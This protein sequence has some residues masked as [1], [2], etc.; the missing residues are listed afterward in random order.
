MTAVDEARAS[1]ATCVPQSS[2]PHRLRPH[3]LVAVAAAVDGLQIH[4]RGT[5]V[6]AC[7]TGKTLVG[8]RVAEQLLADRT[9]PRVLVL[10]PSIA[11][12]DQSFREWRQN[13]TVPFT[14]LAICSDV[15]V[16]DDEDRDERVDELPLTVTTDVEKVDRWLA[17]DGPGMQVVFC[18]YHSSPLLITQDEEREP[19]DL[20]IADEAHRCAGKTDGDFK[21]I[22]ADD[23]IPADKRLFLTAT[24]RITGTQSNTDDV[25]VATMDNEKYFGPRLH[26]LTFREAIDLGLLSDY[27][28]AIITVTDQD[29]HRLVLNHTQLRLTDDPIDEDQLDAATLAAQLA[30]INAAKEHALHRVLVFH[31]RL[32]R[33]RRF[34]K[35]LAMTINS[36]AVEDRPAARL[37]A[38]HIEGA[39]DSE[40]KSFILNHLREVGQAGNTEWMVLSNVKCLSEGID[41]PTLDGIMF[42]EPRTSQIDVAQAVGR[43]IRL[44]PLRQGQPAL[45]ILPVYLNEAESPE[46][47]IAESEFRHIYQTI[48]AL[49]DHDEDFAAKLQVAR[50]RMGQGLPPQIPDNITAINASRGLD[51]QFIDAFSIRLIERTTVSWEAYFGA[52]QQHIQRHD[53][54]PLKS[55]VTDDGLR[56]GQWALNQRVL[57][58]AGQLNPERLRR[59]EAFEC[60]TW[61]PRNATWEANFAALQRY[62]GEHGS[63]PTGSYVTDDGLRIG[64]WVSNLRGLYHQGSLTPDRISRL[65]QL[66]GWTWS[67]GGGG[68]RDLPSWESRFAALE[69]YV[70]QH[71]SLPGYTYVCDDGFG[72]GK[73]IYHQRARYARG[74]L[75]DD[76]A[77][78]LEVLPGWTWNRRSITRVAG[79]D[80]SVRFAALQAYV[81]EHASIPV[82]TCVT[83]DGFK[84]GKWVSSQRVSYAKGRLP[85]DRIEQLEQIPGWLWNAARSDSTDEAWAAK[86][87]VLSQYVAENDA[88]PTYEHVADDGVRLGR[89]I[90]HQRDAHTRGRLSADRVRLL[91]GLPH[92]TWRRRQRD[93]LTSTRWET[94]FEAL[95]R[96]LAHNNDIIPDKTVVDQDGLPVGSWVARMRQRYKSG[97]L[98]ADYIRRLEE[99]DGWDWSPRRA[100]WDAHYQG[101]KEFID[102]H[103]TFPP[104]TYV[105]DDG[106]DLGRW[107]YDQRG[108]YARGRMRADRIALL[109]Q[110][111]DWAWQVRE[112]RDPQMWEAKFAALQRYTEQH[113]AL[114]STDHVDGD[115]VAIGQFIRAQRKAYKSGDL[116]IGRV[117]LLEGLTAWRWGH[118]AGSEWDIKYLAVKQYISEFGELP[119]YSYVTED[120]IRI[121]KWINE[122]RNTHRHG[123][124]TSE[125]VELLEELDHWSWYGPG[126]GNRHRSGI[127]GDHA[128]GGHVVDAWEGKLAALRQY[129]VDHG[130]LPLATYVSDSGL[131][132][133]Q[134]I[135]HQ[136]A[137]YSRG[138]MRPDRIGQLEEIPGWAWRIYRR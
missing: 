120:G 125:R 7:G 42:A 57:Y 53:A 35:T 83:G 128:P 30:V 10:F 115:G 108:N 38:E 61:D 64:N 101:L 86:F 116:T 63:A 3:Q 4:D 74:A 73:W 36:I 70:G 110:L 97:R 55:Y 11:L 56:L 31:N 92:W 50:Q 47:A 80:W 78:R 54:V 105:S 85:A 23:L 71:G 21:A 90:G 114:P 29:A 117:R 107:I 62:I 122:Q 69:T 27:Q 14:A 5:V 87:E 102:V 51:E 76:R 1:A 124:L 91:E 111:K 99:L 15:T 48:S 24:P 33:A 130:K 88:L 79:K 94:M 49:A 134:W 26:T 20:I 82:H 113:G 16:G 135:Q 60:W 123:Q 17:S 28:V 18:T 45:V 132:L 43:A 121:G 72:L 44:N 118:A 77:R 81:D 39:Y 12:L 59:L 96:Y 8:Q 19:W 34:T 95:T 112:A 93:M 6:M 126:S 67:G 133:G 22:L 13:A 52:L 9:R 89:W 109:E 84:L 129:V 136:R 40:T 137:V 100:A 127:V 103:Q 58:N 119:Y 41:V 98:N 131:R 68:R 25:E 65:E 66:D 46:A 75:D 104:P 138:K 2:E 106:L 32:K 37:I